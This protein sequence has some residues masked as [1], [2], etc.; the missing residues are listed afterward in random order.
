L[1]SLSQEVKHKII[2]Q[3]HILDGRKVL[4]GCARVYFPQDKVGGYGLDKCIAIIQVQSW[5]ESFLVE[6]F[7]GGTE[8]GA[9]E[10]DRL[11]NYQYFLLEKM[12]QSLTISKVESFLVSQSVTTVSLGMTMSDGTPSQESA[13]GSVASLCKT[14]LRFSGHFKSSLEIFKEEKTLEQKFVIWSTRLS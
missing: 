7:D 1:S 3:T 14:T 12:K 6:S 5:M 9:V 8:P 13:A 10:W 2:S 4:E 11:G